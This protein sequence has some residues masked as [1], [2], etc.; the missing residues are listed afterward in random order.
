[1]ARTNALDRV[2]TGAKDNG[3][4]WVDVLRSNN[5]RLYRFNRIVI[6]EIERT[7]ED[8]AE[9]ARHFAGAPTNV[10]GFSNALFE[11][12]QRQ[13]R[14]RMEIARTVVDDIRDMASGT[15]SVWERVANNSR[16]TVTATADAGRRAASRVAS[17]A[18]D[19]AEEVSES[20][21]KAARSLRSSPR[22]KASDN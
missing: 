5:D 8:N 21:D 20:A 6:D 16:E 13:A 4:V 15:R 22:S 11:T 10:G 1:M 18:A 17:Q 3:D 12:W 19:V 9:L 7:Q 14:R 2:I